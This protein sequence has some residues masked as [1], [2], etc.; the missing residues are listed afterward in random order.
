MLDV[1]RFAVVALVAA[2][3]MG[4]AT[5]WRN[6][7]WRPAKI[8]GGMLLLCGGLLLGCSGGSTP[9][10]TPGRGT[11]PGSYNVTV[12]AYTVTGNGTTPEATVSIPLTV[13]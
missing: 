3:L 10:P 8:L 1:A 12:N 5:K 4:F 7:A 13:N 6:R 2:V 11:T 9:T